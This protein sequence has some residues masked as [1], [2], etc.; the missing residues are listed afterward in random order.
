MFLVSCQNAAILCSW[1]PVKILT[2]CDPDVLSKHTYPVFLM[3]SRNA[4]FLCFWFLS[5]YPHTVFMTSSQNTHIPLLMSSQNAHIM[6]LFRPLKWTYPVTQ[7]LSPHSYIPCT[8]CFPVQHVICPRRCII[9]ST[10][11][12]PEVLYV[13][14]YSFPL[15]CTREE[16]YSR[17]ADWYSIVFIGNR[18]LQASRDT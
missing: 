18:I 8:W 16:L 5:K 13:S 4:Y 11:S 12:V 7:T 10:S 2:P 15:T 1:S 14:L 6:C 9:S 17:K 3:S